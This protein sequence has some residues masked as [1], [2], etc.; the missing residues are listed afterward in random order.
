[1]F[2]SGDF[3]ATQLQFPHPW[4]LCTGKKAWHPL[5]VEKLEAAFD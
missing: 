1:M 2:A 4:G 3:K 5:G